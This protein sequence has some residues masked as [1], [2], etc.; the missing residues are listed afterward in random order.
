M[1]LSGKRKALIE[2]L[3][4]EGYL[5]SERVI[6][7]FESVPREDF[8][9][10]ECR[11]HAYDDEP[12]PLFAGQTISAPSMIAVM[13]ELLELK[14]GD[15]V[16]EVGAGSGYNAALLSKLVKEVCAIELDPGL[17]DFARDNLR[18]AGIKNVKVMQGDG[19]MGYGKASPYDKIIIT[20]ACPEI[21]EPLIRQLK[22]GGRVVAPVGGG[23]RQELV[24]GIKKG[25]R[26]RTRDCGGCIFVPLR[27]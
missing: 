16:L 14:P 15:R 11:A 2:Q 20:C 3:K 18:R 17:A 23:W 7:A 10:E 6:K 22:E 9:P 25:D 24:L 26:L 21:P 8:V 13:L 27:H 4:R 1:E 19:S 5:K 12:L